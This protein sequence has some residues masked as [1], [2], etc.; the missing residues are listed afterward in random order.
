MGRPAGVTSKRFH[1]GPHDVEM[2]RVA[3]AP[4]IVE[5]QF[6]GPEMVDS[7]VALDE[8][9]EHRDLMQRGGVL[10][11]VVLVIGGAFGR[12]QSTSVQ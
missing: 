10:A 4:A 9:V 2:A 6:G 7:A 1:R 12:Q 11:Q 5:G 8:N 3:G